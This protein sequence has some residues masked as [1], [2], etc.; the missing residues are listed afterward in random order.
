M[1]SPSPIPESVRQDFPILNQRLSRGDTSVALVYLDNAATT[2]KPRAVIDALAE[3][4]QTSNANV[5]RG[6]HTLGERSTALFEDARETVRQFLNAG[7]TSEVIFTRGTTESI[8]LVASSY[9]EL[10]REGDE[11]IVTEMEHHA[12]LVPWF[13]LR[14]RR[15]VR[16]VVWPLEDDGTLDLDRLPA[17]LT[18]RTRLVA[19]TAMS[20]VVGTINPIPRIA[21]IVHAHGALLLVDG[22]Q[23]VP[24]LGADVQTLGADFLAFSAH[25][26][27]GPMGIGVLWSREELLERMPPYQGGGEMI[28]VVRLDG[29]EPNV[30]P[31]KF[32]AGTPNV[33][34][35]V[36]LAAAIRYLQGIGFQ[37]IREHDRLLLQRTLE[38]LEDLD[39]V[40]LLGRAPER[41]A[42]VAFTL[43][44]V[45]AHDL[46]AWLDRRG[47]AVRAG[48]H[49]AHPLARRYGIVSSVRASYYFY[50]TLE[51]VDLFL[52]ALREARRSL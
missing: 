18:P 49:C 1:P 11:V 51:E 43:E 19:I 9:G 25:K 37:A 30:L 3:Y 44:G 26:M 40:R 20:N 16:L 4:Y 46:A 50:N 31:Y 36:G 33:E 13:L 41:G 42:L 5:H 14:N 27:C 28:R 35:A 24:H 21:E 38:G 29:F 22:A 48:H 15:G 34:G 45:H 8:N 23:A 10:L 17:L 7:R 2:Q 52:E 39:G 6:I 12:N 47:I 32:E